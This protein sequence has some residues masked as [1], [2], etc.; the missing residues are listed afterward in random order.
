MKLQN[1]HKFIFHL[2]LKNKRKL[3]ATA[4]ARPAATHDEEISSDSG[5]DVESHEDDDHNDQL[6][7]LEE[8]ETAQEKKLR[9]ARRFIEQIEQRMSLLYRLKKSLI[10]NF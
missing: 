4:A 6:H 3:S 8:E 5:S 1:T 2:M 10:I 7:D 9:L